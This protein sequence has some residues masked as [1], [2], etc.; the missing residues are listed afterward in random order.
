MFVFMLVTLGCA[1]VSSA[2][3]QFVASAEVPFFVDAPL[4]DESASPIPWVIVLHT[5]QWW[6]GAAQPAIE[7]DSTEAVVDGDGDPHVD[8]DGD[9]HVGATYGAPLLIGTVW[10]APQEGVATRSTPEDD[11]SRFAIS[12]RLPRGPPI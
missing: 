3:E 6:D 11:P 12:A 2:A 8:G 9:P 4:A 5:L 10:L 1:R 7:C